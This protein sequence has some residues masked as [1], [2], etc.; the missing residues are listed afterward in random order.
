LSKCKGTLLKNQL[1]II[2]AGCDFVLPTLRNKK[3]IR[4][5]RLLQKVTVEFKRLHQLIKEPWKVL[6]FIENFKLKIRIQKNSHFSPSMKTKNTSDPFA[7]VKR[8]CKRNGN[9]TILLMDA[10]PINLDVISK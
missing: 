8:K 9:Q 10:A 3:N 2:K 1:A 5:L 4:M 7:P 6:R